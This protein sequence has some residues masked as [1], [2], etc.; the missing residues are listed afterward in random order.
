MNGLVFEYR[1]TSGSAVATNSSALGV[2]VMATD[3]NA[4]A[5]NF[6][7]KQMMES[8]EFSSSTV[9]FNSALHPVECKPLSN[10]Q[11]SYYIRSGDAT[12]T[13]QQL[14]DMGNFQLATSGMQSAYV[15]GELWVTYDVSLLKP[16]V[17]TNMSQNDY[18]HLNEAP[19][20][21]ATAAHPLGTTAGY[22]FSSSTLTG[23]GASLTNPTTSINFPNPGSY[24]VSFNWHN[25]NGTMAAVATV[26]PGSNI[27][28]GGQTTA[29]ILIDQSTFAASCLSADGTS[30][31]WTGIFTVT[32]AGTTTANDLVI[33]GLT[34]MT[35]SKFDAMIFGLPN[36]LGS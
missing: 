32:A 7:S 26:T 28:N 21:S 24:Y 18:C 22:V 20:G 9:P 33:T 8:Y 27:K 11:N 5:P 36:N 16:R 17:S 10:T 15:V 31:S 23:V 14:F 35:A 4:A 30:S 25:G 13:N 1:P 3:Y 29:S 19:A 34:S 12:V 6:T 2:V